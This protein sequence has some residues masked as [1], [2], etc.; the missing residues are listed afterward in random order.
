M[1]GLIRIVS[2]LHIGHRASMIDSLQAL[3]PLAEG[4]DWLIFNGDTLELKY[5]DSNPTSY[6][7]SKQKQLFDDEVAKWPC[8][9]TLITGNHDP[10]I[11][12]IHSLSILQGQVFITHGDSLFREIAPWSSNIRNLRRF[13]EHIDPAATGQ[14]DQDLHDYLVLHKQASLLAHQHD[15][16]YN[17][18]VWGKFKI[19]LHQAWPPTRPFKILKCWAEVPDRAVSLATR[20]GRAPRYIVVGHTHRPG[21]WNRGEQTV[22]NLGSYFPWP[23]ALCIDIDARALIVRK[24]RKRQN[25]IK[26]GSSIA[27]YQLE[28]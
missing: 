27:S 1:P 5:G 3:R 12:E 8:K 26:I 14:T 22:I 4:A 13:S 20:F 15:K 7:S 16:D 28:R 18:T 11:S 21:T 19:F 10:E 2:D 24:I 6:D 9:V 25:K 17:P 23:G